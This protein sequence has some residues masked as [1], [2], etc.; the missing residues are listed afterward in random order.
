MLESLYFR[1]KKLNP[2]VPKV[3]FFTLG[4]KVNQYE[5]AALAGLFLSKGYQVVDFGEKADVYVI[6]TCTV[7]HISDR[8][9]RQA[10]R[11]A[12]KANPEAIV[13]VTGCYA[14]TASTEVLAIPGVD[15]VIGTGERSRIV[16][17]VEGINRSR[18]SSRL[19]SNKP[20]LKK[21]VNKVE[22]TSHY[23]EFEEISSF[24]LQ[25]RA[26]AFLKIQEGCNN[27]C[28]YCIVPYARGP[29]RSRQ[30]ENILDEAQ[31]LIEKGF[32]EIVLTGI[33]IGAYGQDLSG[34]I[35]L[36][37]LIKLLTEMPGLGRL[38]LSSIEPD[39]LTAGLV[40]LIA[41][42]PTICRHL[43]IPLQSGDD[44]ILL[45]MK[46]GYTRDSYA[47]LMESIRL[48]IPDI[49]ITTDIMV[50][51]PGEKEEN[52]KNSYN[53]VKDMNFAGL[54]VFKYSPRK[55]TPAAS[56]SDQVPP[57]VKEERS[58]AFIALGKKLADAYASQF[59]GKVLFVIV[60]K[61]FKEE[62]SFYEGLSDNYLRIIFPGK[63]EMIGNLVKVYIERANK[64]LNGRI[65]S[66]SNRI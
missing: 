66:D 14:Q 28:A 51:F 52:F 26:R 24:P 63:E 41:S 65:I 42:S 59:V 20:T 22:E 48:K 39:D 9:S 49:A 27:F 62:G 1:E 56:F 55:N 16:Q 10:I 45:S 15:L 34:R 38:R 40:E 36:V 17:L 11:R 4:C 46:R 43:H 30:P 12:T 53:F 3:A 18:L 23:Q 33:H 19:N 8:K 6:N 13:V 25:E 47:K 64:F 7:T 58:R 54:H 32:K 31:K 5:T 61:L 57:V 29:L 35:K 21:P 60:E 50:G 44:Y 2:V 37:E